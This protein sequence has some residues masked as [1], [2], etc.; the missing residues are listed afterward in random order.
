MLF[1][2]LTFVVF[3]AIVLGVY[4]LL[5]GWS[6]RKGWLLAASYVFY[7]AWNPPFALLLAASTLV[8]WWA[9]LRLESAERTSSRRGWLLLSLLANFGVL[10]WFKY[11]HFLMENTLSLLAGMGVEA[12]LPKYDIILP[13]GIS[14]YTFQT[15]SYTIDVYR[16]NLKAEPS[17]RDFAVY[18]SFFPQLVAGPIVRASDFLYQLASPPRPEPGRMGW[19]LFLMT[20]GLFQKMVLADT[21]LAPTVEAV[22]AHDFPLAT[23]DA[24]AGALAFSFQ[25]LFDFAGYSTCAIG[26]ALCFG[27]SLCD[28]FRY[29]YAAVGFSDFWRRW[30]ISLSSWLRD[31]LYIPL[32]GNRCGMIRNSINL[33]L[34][35]LLGGLWHGA[36]WNFVIWGGLHGLYLLLERFVRRIAG[37]ATWGTSFPAVCLAWLATFLG[38]VVTWVFFR[39]A[40]LTQALHLIGDMAGGHA[41]DGD[42]IIA[43]RELLQVGLITVAVLLIHRVMRERS[44]ESVVERVPSWMLVAGWA[45]MLLSL[46]LARGNGAAFIYFQF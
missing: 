18:V 7:G 22:F 45:G 10:G 25:I 37:D 42:R 30:H 21:L 4:H 11:G 26:A 16:R 14:F 29:P 6:V 38:V 43:G 2:S 9:G 46:G 20:L 28:N 39:A 17:L 33:M 40:D 27:F 36:G 15:L 31:Y 12:H 13:V 44:I 5:S 8:D 23:I 41:S 34:V 19:G 32:G 35:M 1:N 24:W 3:F